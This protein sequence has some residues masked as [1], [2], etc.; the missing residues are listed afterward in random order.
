MAD[1]TRITIE[2]V[3]APSPVKRTPSSM[4]PSV[5]P[6]VAKTIESPRTTKPLVVDKKMH[7]SNRAGGES[8]VEY[9]YSKT[10]TTSRVRL[11]KWSDALSDWEE[12]DAT[13]LT[14]QEVR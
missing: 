11:Y 4:S 10:E 2:C 1:L 13:A 14:G 6:V 7:Y 8:H 12:I 9:V 3:S 5:T